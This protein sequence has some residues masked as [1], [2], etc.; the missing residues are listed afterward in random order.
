MTLSV[1]W[2]SNYT[3]I[4][5]SHVFRL[6][7]EPGLTAWMSR[8]LTTQPT[9]DCYCVFFMISIIQNVIALFCK[10]CPVIKTTLKQSGTVGLLPIM[11]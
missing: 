2:T 1:D 4:L 6:G 11:L 8:A 7:I 3:G 10:L 5:T 9:N